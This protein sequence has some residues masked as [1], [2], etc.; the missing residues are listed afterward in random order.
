MS[1]IFLLSTNFHGFQSGHQIW[2]KESLAIGRPV[3]TKKQA[4]QKWYHE[5]YSR[6]ITC[7]PQSERQPG[8]LVDT[9]S[10]HSVRRNAVSSYPG[11]NVKMHWQAKLL[12][13]LQFPTPPLHIRTSARRTL[14]SFRQ[15]KTPS[16]S[17][18]MQREKDNGIWKN[19]ENYEKL[20]NTNKQQW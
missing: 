13:Y 4:C 15:E 17:H 2:S 1:W 11:A 8:E 12:I 16:E 7:R 6:M 19:D 10:L 14:S 18:M 5:V 3:E 20:E 9:S